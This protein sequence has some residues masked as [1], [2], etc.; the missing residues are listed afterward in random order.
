MKYKNIL[1]EI[2]ILLLFVFIIII[3]NLLYS[4][5]RFDIR[6]DRIFGSTYFESAIFSFEL[7]FVFTFLYPIYLIIRKGFKKPFLFGFFGLIGGILSFVLAGFLY[8]A[9]NN[10]WAGILHVFATYLSPIL[11]LIGGA[12]MVIG[13]VR[14]IKQTTIKQKPSN[15]LRPFLNNPL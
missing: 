12:Y 8:F 7:I 14:R 1:Q 4:S 11:A 3:S 6:L 5:F 10:D 13:I 2:T 15:P 9:C